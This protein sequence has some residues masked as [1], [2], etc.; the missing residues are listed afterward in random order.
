MFMTCE[1]NAGQNHSIKAANKSSERVAKFK[2]LGT[3]LTKFNAQRHYEQ[4]K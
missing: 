2:Y 3:T 4:I 1:H